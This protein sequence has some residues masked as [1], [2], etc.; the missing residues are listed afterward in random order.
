MVAATT[1]R[2]ITE[3]GSA[4][5]ALLQPQDCGHAGLDHAPDVQDAE[6]QAH[7][8]RGER[9]QPTAIDADGDVDVRR[10]AVHEPSDRG[11]P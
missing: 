6:E 9:D 7:R 4:M 5:S 10:S 3:H 2:I 1:G 11:A 8:G